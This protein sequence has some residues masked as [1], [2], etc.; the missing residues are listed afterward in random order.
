M[1]A[2]GQIAGVVAFIV[3]VLLVPVVGKLCH[4]WSLF[5]WPGP[6]RI[7]SRPI[8]R[9]GG[10]AVAAA[11]ACGVLVTARRFGSST[12][13]SSFLA[14]FALI[15]VVGL[16]DDLWGLSPVSRIA[17]HLA[18]GVLLW[19]AG[20]Q[21]PGL[22]RGMLGLILVCLFVIIFVNALNFLDGADG[23]ATGVAGII[24]TAYI[25]L[26][27]ATN[28]ALA[29]AVAWSLAGTCAAFLLFNFPL[30]RI[31]LGDSGS[32]ALGFAIAFLG[33]DFYRSRPAGDASMFLP[34][35]LAGLPLL[36]AA[37]TVIRRLRSPLS[38]I[39]G[40]RRHF[41]DL[42]LARGWSARRVALTCYLITAGLGAIG[43]IGERKGPNE[44]LAVAV[45]SVG[46]LLAAALRLGALRQDPAERPSQ[47]ERMNCQKGVVGIPD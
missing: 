30:A 34:L 35:M 14:P 23:L 7:H 33:L 39:H 40:D 38:L 43:W 19:H 22:G 2:T 18:A 28:D 3:A 4:R 26:P 37:L 44:F 29:S 27:G 5:D 24:A 47:K 25:V 46:G 10:V 8:P 31:F 32:T 21:L 12:S 42:L 6:L 45:L 9:L 36:D 15:W 1:K 17:A 41:Y 20:W 13:V 16:V 11:I